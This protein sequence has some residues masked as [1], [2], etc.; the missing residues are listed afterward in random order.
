MHPGCRPVLCYLY[1]R[2][3]WAKGENGCDVC[4]CADPPIRKFKYCIVKKK[5]VK[6]PIL[7]ISYK[8]FYLGLKAVDTIGNCQSL[9]FTVGV[10]Q[11]MHKITNL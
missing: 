9:A 1:C 8:V 4:Q 7:Y 10:S 3:G 11:H 5:T 2:H 6:I